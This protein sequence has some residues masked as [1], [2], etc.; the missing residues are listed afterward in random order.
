MK[1]LLFRA[2][3]RLQPV[4]IEAIAIEL[5]VPAPAVFR[6]MLGWIAT[7]LYAYSTLSEEDLLKLAAHFPITPFQSDPKISTRLLGHDVSA[8]THAMAGFASIQP[9][10]A[11][12][13]LDLAAP[14]TLQL[15]LEY[16]QHLSN[17]RPFLNIEKQVFLPLIPAPIA[18][19]L[20]I[21]IPEKS[22]EKLSSSDFTVWLKSLLLLLAFALVLML[23]SRHFSPFF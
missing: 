5:N 7:C 8:H 11:R 19:I 15:L 12:R 20:G 16:R 23:L 4:W 3:N 22:V 1:E 21:N 2:K 10:A 6:A 18:A 14:F 9:M 13:L 17:I